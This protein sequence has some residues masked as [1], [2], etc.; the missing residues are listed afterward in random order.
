MTYA[1]LCFANVCLFVCLS[2]LLLVCLSVCQSVWLV[3]GL[4][5]VCLFA[6]LLVCLLVGWLV[7]LF[8]CLFVLCMCLLH[9]GT[10]AKVGKPQNQEPSPG[11]PGSCAEKIQVGRRLS[12]NSDHDLVIAAIRATGKDGSHER[13]LADWL[14]VF[15]NAVRL[16]VTPCRLLLKPT[17][18]MLCRIR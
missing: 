4:M 16:W 1:S 15:S 11:L 10:V 18:S 3:G 7:G 14:P 2:A 9:G 12:L 5:F 6:C 8:A 17:L 13:E